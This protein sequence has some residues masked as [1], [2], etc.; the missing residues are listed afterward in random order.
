MSLQGKPYFFFGR[1]LL[2][3]HGNIAETGASVIVST[4]GPQARLSNPVSRAVALAAGGVSVMKSYLDRL[5]PIAEGAIA[6]TPAG[7]IAETKYIFHVVPT[8]KAEGRAAN[9]EYIDR[10]TRRAVRRA[11]L[12][13]VESLAIPPMGGGRGRAD[14]EEVVR[15]ILEAATSSLADCR[16]LRTV[17]FATTN[18]ATYLRYHNQIVISVVLAQRRRE[19]VAVLP[20]MQPG[21]YGSFG[22]VLLEMAAVHEQA[23]QITR[24]RELHAGLEELED[25]VEVLVRDATALIQTLPAEGAAVEALQAVINCGYNI[26]YNVAIAQG[27]GS[28]AASGGGVAAGGNVYG[29][30]QAAAGPVSER[31]LSSTSQRKGAN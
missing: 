24:Q 19:V 12:L 31:S 25:R 15:V 30:I 9:V 21:L 13:E 29:D 23:G 7:K 4:T 5:T 2:P 28:V 27:T 18:A 10:L 17:L 26:V 14:K 3:Y 11:D 8:A 22:R 6:I 16:H 1:E 20:M